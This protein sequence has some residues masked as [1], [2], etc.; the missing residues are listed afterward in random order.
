MIGR[1]CFNTLSD[2]DKQRVRSSAKY[3]FLLCIQFECTSMFIVLY[4]INPYE[5]GHTHY[6]V[7]DEPAK[8]C[9]T[10]ETFLPDFIVILEWKIQDD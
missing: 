8:T 2:E 3:Y 1:E 7:I 9:S 10:K 4:I 6:V 5:A